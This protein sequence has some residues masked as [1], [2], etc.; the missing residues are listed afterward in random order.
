MPIEFKIKFTAESLKKTVLNSYVKP[1]KEATNNLYIDIRK[2]SPIKTGRYRSW[3]KNLWVRV[4]KDKVVWTVENVWEYPQ[5]IETGWKRKAVNW[6]LQSIW[7]IYHS[8]GANVYKKAVE[9]NKT[10]FLRKIKWV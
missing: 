7:Q 5:K 9:K 2:F 8:V 10:I 4:F 6:N 3:H 1:V